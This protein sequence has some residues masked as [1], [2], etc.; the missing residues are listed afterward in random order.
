MLLYSVGFLSA[1]L[2]DV[3]MILYTILSLIVVS[4][5]KEDM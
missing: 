2:G 3:G 4:V 5:G 1:A